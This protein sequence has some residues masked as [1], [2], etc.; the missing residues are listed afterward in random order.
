MKIFHRTGI[1]GLSSEIKL[2]CFHRVCTDGSRKFGMQ[3]PPSG[4]DEA[5]R[6]LLKKLIKQPEKPLEKEYT[7]Q[8]FDGM[9]DTQFEWEVEPPVA[10]YRLVAYEL[11][12]DWRD[13]S[14]GIFWLDY[15]IN[16]FRPREPP[17]PFIESAPNVG[18]TEKL[19]IRF[20]RETMKSYKI[21]ANTWWVPTRIQET[22]LL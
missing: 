11:I 12:N 8:W 6:T 7:N 18:S 2:P 22:D 15:P 16:V 3:E 1:Q 17:Q 21:R 5:T 4:L 9:T 13:T 10:G 14:N 20:Q 19:L